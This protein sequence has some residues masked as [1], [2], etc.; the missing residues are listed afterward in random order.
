MNERLRRYQHLI[1]DV[2]PYPPP[3]AELNFRPMFGGLGIY[4]R[5]R[6]FAFVTDEGLAFKLDDYAQGELKESTP[7]AVNLSW[8]R[9]YLIVPSYIED[10]QARLEDWIQRSLGYVWSLPPGKRGKKR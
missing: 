8:T 6:I 5:G 10:D 1:E 2:C 3:E 7:G 9:K 4:T